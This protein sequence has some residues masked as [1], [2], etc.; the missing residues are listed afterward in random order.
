MLKPILPGAPQKGL[1]SLPG[2]PPEGD[3]SPRTQHVEQGAGGTDAGRVCS[4][5]SIL[6]RRQAAAAFLF[7]FKTLLSTSWN[8]G[9]EDRR[10]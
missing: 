8:I 4:K 1:R 10:E 9:L 2:H 6:S 5:P 7:P 3:G